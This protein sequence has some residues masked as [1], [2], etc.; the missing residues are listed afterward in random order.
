MIT[1]H[2][3]PKEALAALV[4]RLEVDSPEEAFAAALNAWPPHVREGRPLVLSEVLIL[5]LKKAPPA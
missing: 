1:R 2:R 4:A 5:P 3:I